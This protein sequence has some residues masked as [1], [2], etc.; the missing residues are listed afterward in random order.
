MESKKEKLCFFDFDDTLIEGDSI[1]YWS[2]FYYKERPWMRIFQPFAWFGFLLR[3]LG[4]I[5]GASV[6]KWVYLPLCYEQSKNVDVLAKKFVDTVLI[7]YWYQE[8]LTQAWEHYRSGYEIAVISASCNFYLKYITSYLPPQ[9]NGEPCKIVGTTMVFPQRGLWRLPT[10]PEGN[11]KGSRKVQY[12]QHSVE[13]RNRI[14]LYGYSDHHSDRYLLEYC[15]TGMVIHPSYKMKGIA[16]QKGWKILY[17]KKKHPGI[18]GKFRKL[19]LL[20]LGV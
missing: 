19:R 11:M 4:L 15:Q 8:L 6:K 12:I 3:S 17:P 13:W 1:L 16:I 9:P 14:A 10:L 2:A 20:L 5:S 7:H 18:M